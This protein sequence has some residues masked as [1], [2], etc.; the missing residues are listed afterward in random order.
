VYTI[1]YGTM[2]APT[3]DGGEFPPHLMTRHFETKDEMDEYAGEKIYPCY[4]AEEGFYI[5][6]ALTV[7]VKI[8]GHDL[9]RLEAISSATGKSPARLIEGLL[10]T[11]LENYLGTRGIWMKHVKGA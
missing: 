9:S 1:T 5:E 2:H 10:E 7:P 3:D 8:S 6:R 4:G 11:E